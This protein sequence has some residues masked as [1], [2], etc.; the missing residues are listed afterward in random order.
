MRDEKDGMVRGTSEMLKEGTK[1]KGLRGW[2]KF[3]SEK[4]EKGCHLIMS[5][6]FDYAI[7]HS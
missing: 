3:K 2:D 6:T 7:H 1:V 4:G 5:D